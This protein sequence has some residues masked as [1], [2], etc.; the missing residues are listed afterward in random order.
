LNGAY[1]PDVQE[2]KVSTGVSSIVNPILENIGKHRGPLALALATHA[3][4]ALLVALAPVLGLRQNVAIF[5]FLPAI[6]VALAFGM[7][8][9]LANA[10]FL[11][12]IE[13]NLALVYAGVSVSAMMGSPGNIAGMLFLLATAYVVGHSRDLRIRLRNVLSVAEAA[14]RD[15]HASRE[16]YRRI[17][18]GL[19][20]NHFFYTHDVNG[21]FTYLSPSVLDVLGYPVQ[22]FLKHYGEYLTDDPVNR[23]VAAH[24]EQ[25]ILGK[26]QPPY[27][28]DIF[29]KDGTRRRLEVSETP[30]FDES[31]R[32][33]AVEGI[34]HDISAR[35]EAERARAESESGFRALFEGTS[36]GV[37][38][39]DPQT[40][41]FIATNPAM[42]A[43]FGYTEEEFRSLGPEDLTPIEAREIM[44]RAM[45]M[46][47]Q[48]QPVP[49]DEGVSVTK[50]GA[51]INV[52]VANRPLTWKGKPAFHI[53]FKDV[54]PLKQVQRRLEEKNKAI[55]DF[56]NMI[57]H[58]LRNPLAGMKATLDMLQVTPALQ[59]DTDALETVGIGLEAA[60]YMESLLSDLLDVARM[61]SGTKT[62]DLQ[63][64]RLRDIVDRVLVPLRLRAREKGIAIGVALENAE[65]VAD[66]GE[67][68][69]VFMNLIG[70]AISYI[71]ERADPCITIGMTGQK[72]VP[73]FF[74]KDNGIGIPVEDRAT[75][76]ERFKRGSNVR[77]TRGTGLGLAIVKGIV[78]AHGGTVRAESAVG[79]GTTFL[80]TLGKSGCV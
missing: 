56:S 23:D 52:I 14:Q 33:V 19:R 31:G 60:R 72:G 9:G 5:S 49:D 48:G 16:K 77:T 61:E 54:T 65:I 26:P 38:L 17:V 47:E 34:A 57:T 39:V 63:R 58:D 28:V 74:V 7:K 76:F 59:S 43:M 75:I 21:V 18:E 40:N 6:G 29:H 73:T 1:C 68:V 8:A 79:E 80:F 35:W 78:E 20:R 27:E 53:T 62:L 13:N 50:T 25:S 4:Y 66:P 3:A 32:V 22:E 11:A 67:I 12:L 30:V 37:A 51:K 71:G 2:S 46:L 41:R 45:Q 10:V 44:R 24:T 69:K 55:M 42:C 70:N 36:E 64:V 15:L